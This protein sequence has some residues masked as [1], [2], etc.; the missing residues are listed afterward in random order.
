[1]AIPSY[2]QSLPSNKLSEIS[3]VKRIYLK[4]NPFPILQGPI[5]NTSEYRIGLEFVGGKRLTYQVAGSYLSKSILFRTNLIPDSTRAL[6]DLFEFPGYRVQ[7]QVRYF[8]I[9]SRFG[10]SIEDYL[11]PS[12][13][14][15]ALHSSYAAATWKQKGFNYPRM[16]WSNFTINALVGFQLIAGDDLGLD[17]FFGIG[18]KENLVYN[19][20]YRMRKT[21]LDIRDAYEGPIGEYMASPFKIS[22]G[23]NFT[24]GLL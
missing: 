18:Y 12:G 7:A 24:F 17:C 21:P 4:I 1:M 14:Y 22:L 15:I 2:T 3:E 11:S 9:K 19:I 5:V 8:F 23:F 13:L 10:K 20:D 16:E 6:S